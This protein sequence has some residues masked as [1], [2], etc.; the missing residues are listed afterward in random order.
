MLQDGT[1]IVA[2]WYTP[3]ARIATFDTAA[4]RYGSDSAG[5]WMHRAASVSNDQ[6]GRDQAAG[7]KS[8]EHTQ[9]PYQIPSSHTKTLR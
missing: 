9:V 7:G 4:A 5:S 1:V 2:G 6:S 8:Q 3:G